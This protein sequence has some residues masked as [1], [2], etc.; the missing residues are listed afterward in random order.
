MK[1]V[2]G[3]RVWP[4]TKLL[5]NQREWIFEGEVS[6]IMAKHGVVWCG[7]VWCEARRG[8]G[9][10]DG[11]MERKCGGMCVRHAWLCLAAAGTV[12]CV[13]WWRAH[14]EHF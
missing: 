3:N 12:V 4:E 5:R 9:E 2:K 13:H 6:T 7:T 8:M 14:W 10:R 1:G 11:K